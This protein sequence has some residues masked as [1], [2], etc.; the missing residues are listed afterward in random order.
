[1]S[2]PKHLK[3]LR[4]KHSLSREQLSEK[5]EL[6]YSTIAKYESGERSPEM[7]TL[8][9]LADIFDV[10][11][12]YLLGRTENPAIIGSDSFP[13]AKK[14]QEEVDPAQ[15]ERLKKLIDI[16]K[17]ASP[18]GRE[19]MIQNMKMILELDRKNRS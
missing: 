2:F 12:D 18:E 15:L 1:M 17:S 3:E 5:L 13:E 4:K 6:S 8:Q 16:F 19:L 9:K 10:S 14:E 7:E 11:V